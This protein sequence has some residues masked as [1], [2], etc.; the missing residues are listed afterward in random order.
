MANRVVIQA[1]IDNYVDAFA[2]S[3]FAMQIGD[4]IINTRTNPGGSDGKGAFFCATSAA[5]FPGTRI[6]ATIWLDGTSL[7]TLYDFRLTNG[8]TNTE[9]YISEPDNFCHI[10]PI[11]GTQVYVERNTVTNNGYTMLILDIA[12]VELNG[13]TDGYP[14][15]RD[16]LG[17]TFL[18]GSFGIHLS[19]GTDL[20]AAHMLSVG[21]PYALG[22]IGH[23]KIIGVEVE[24]GFSAVRFEG[25]NY[26]FIADFTVKRSYLHD[27]ISGEGF[28]LGAT[29]GP[30]YT[31]LR[32]LNIEDMIITRRAAESI[33]IQH[34]IDGGTRAEIKNFVIY[35]GDSDWMNAFQPFQ[36]AAIQVSDDDGNHYMANGVI[37]GY[38]S[39]GYVVYGSVPTL[40]EPT[41]TYTKP[42]TL[43]NCLF[44]SARGSFL[45]IN[46]STINGI[47]WEYDKIYLRH[48]TNEY[49]TQT[50]E[51]VTMYYIGQNNGTDTHHFTRIKVD[52]QVKTSIFQSISNKFEIINVATDGSL[53]NS[54]Y[55]PSYVRSGFYETADKIKGNWY[56]VWGA[57]FQNPTNTPIIFYVGDIVSGV[58]D[59]QPFRMYKCIVQHSST[60]LTR[61]DLDSTH[62][63]LLRW[64]TFGVRNDQGGYNSATIQSYYPP[65]DF[66]LKADSYWNLEGMGLSTN[67]PNTLYTQYQ[68]FRARYS[69]GTDSVPI[70]GGKILRYKFTDTDKS[71]YARLGIRV[72]ASN[73]DYG[74]WKYSAWKL[75]T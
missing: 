4:V 48:F 52:G 12:Y 45:Y 75:V 11:P 39:T 35:A 34:L 54:Q 2:G 29:H 70:P 44:N 55:E 32:N 21:V 50:Q 6:G 72:K 33:Q 36:D 65:D 28:Y 43:Q 42:I 26:E 24:H 3:H 67:E 37:D 9:W 71:M 23:F 64:D 15:M 20:N 13:E 47:R 25:G 62:W 27:G 5:T 56:S 10:R 61:P 19:G 38:S 69:D 60:S 53:T 17:Q 8:T 41:P 7:G 63:L 30:P 1:D 46:N 58:V 18:R 16:G 59:T 66:R 49:Y 40:P 14:G 68:W 73:G 22:R 57:Y 74:D 51:P 31:K